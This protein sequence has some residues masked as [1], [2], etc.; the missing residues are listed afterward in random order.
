LY[1]DGI[2][3]IPKNP[4]FE[5]TLDKVIDCFL[6]FNPTILEISESETSNSQLLLNK[7]PKGKIIT[8]NPNASPYNFL[9]LNS[10]NSFDM[11]R[12]TNSNYDCL[13]K[14]KKIA[15][16]ISPAIFSIKT[17]FSFPNYKASFRRLKHAL[18]T[19]NYN[20][21]CFWQYEGSQ[22]EAVFIKKEIYNAIFH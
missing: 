2:W 3:N 21:I 19:R 13:L 12:A 20:L 16:L 8:F 6:P 5:W 7:F 10:F 15:H 11:I 9:V 4:S 22:G 14:N 17:D 1:T 18:E